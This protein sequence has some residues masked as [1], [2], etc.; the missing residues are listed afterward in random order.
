[1]LTDRVRFPGREGP[2]SARD[3]CAESDRA[4][5]S[6]AERHTARRR[7]FLREE[8]CVGVRGTLSV[9]DF[10]Y[11]MVGRDD[12]VEHRQETHELGLQKARWDGECS[13]RGRR[14]D[15]TPCC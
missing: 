14:N 10:H 9:I 2:G 5:E 3:L 8:V 6:L 12:G 4:M 11:L 7:A 15:S 1:R 13:P